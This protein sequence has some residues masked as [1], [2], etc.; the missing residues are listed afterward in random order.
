[1]KQIAGR[2]GRAGGIYPEGEVSTFDDEDLPLLAQ[3]MVQPSEPVIAAGLQPNTEQVVQFAESWRGIHG[4]VPNLS[5]LLANFLEASQLD[6][7]YFM[8]DN[9]EV[10]HRQ[11]GWC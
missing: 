11:G 9:N 8:C 3:G 1:M 7:D 4:S 10:R 6:G 2:A 5:R